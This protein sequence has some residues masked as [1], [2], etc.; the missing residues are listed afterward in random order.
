[1]QSLLSPKVKEFR[2]SVNICRSSGQESSVLFYWLT[3]YYQLL[4][5]RASSRRGVSCHVRADDAED[6]G[7]VSSGVYYAMHDLFPAFVPEQ[8]MADQEEGCVAA[9][10]ELIGNITVSGCWFHYCLASCRPALYRTGLASG[11]SRFFTS[12]ASGI[13]VMF[14]IHEL[15]YHLELYVLL[16]WWK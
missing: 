15:Y 6:A 8:L 2:K 13:V 12:C 4:S 11:I 10:Q 1:M 3:G 14:E 5:V 16:T 7:V 9:F